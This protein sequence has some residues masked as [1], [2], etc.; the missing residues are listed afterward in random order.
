MQNLAIRPR[1]AFNRKKRTSNSNY[2]SFN[3]WE[4]AAN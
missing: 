3:K 4:N 2:K 1:H